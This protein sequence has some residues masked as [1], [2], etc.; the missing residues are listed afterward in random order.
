MFFSLLFKV[1]VVHPVM[2]TVIKVRKQIIL[3]AGIL[4]SVISPGLFSGLFSLP[5]GL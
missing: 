2:A 5:G 3:N 4:T 1:I